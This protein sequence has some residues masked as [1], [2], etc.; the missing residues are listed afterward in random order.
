MRT[1]GAQPHACRAEH[2]HA[3]SQ[4][5]LVQGS[6]HSLLSNHHHTVNS[7][8]GPSHPSMSWQAE[9]PYGLLSCAGL[10]TPDP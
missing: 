10:L 3:V 4:A 7:R 8:P 2:S 6:R 1:P 5:S 9:R